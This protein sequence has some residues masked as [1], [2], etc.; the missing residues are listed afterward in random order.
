MYVFGVLRAIETATIPELRLMLEMLA[1]ELRER[2][3]KLPAE[4]VGQA[5]A[6]IEKLRT[7]DVPREK[8]EGHNGV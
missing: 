1:K 4:H 8:K 3:L 7:G 2:G 6:E 5:V